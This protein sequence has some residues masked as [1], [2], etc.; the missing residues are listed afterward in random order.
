MRAADA[1]VL[2]KANSRSGRELSR[3]DLT[4]GRIHD[5]AKLAPLLIG[6]RSQQVLNLRDAFSHES[7]SGWL[8]RSARSLEGR[9][10]P[11]HRLHPCPSSRDRSQSRAETSGASK[12]LLGC[13]RVVQKVNGLDVLWVRGQRASE[14]RTAAADAI[15]RRPDRREPGRCLPKSAVKA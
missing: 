9:A 7:R 3:F 2:R 13:N 1:P 10:A 12:A 5:L 14:R 4:D 11:S 15:G 6:N 8:M